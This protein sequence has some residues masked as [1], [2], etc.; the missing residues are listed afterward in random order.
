MKVLFV[1]KGNTCR[2]PMAEA[3]LRML[4]PEW[5]VAS[6]GTK[7]NC[8]G[9]SASSHAQSV[10]ADCGG[11]LADHV[12]REFTSEMA[13]QD[14]IIFVMAESN[15]TEILKIAPDA[16]TKVKLL[17]GKNDI[18]NPFRG[19]LAKYEKVF[20]CIKIAVENFVNESYRAD[21]LIFLTKRG[22][23]TGPTAICRQMR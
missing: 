7:K 22:V 13:A 10:I 12:S 16:E 6:A 21:N 5:T 20:N 15:K 9:K 19:D 17:G 2:S 23:N 3:Y 8:G 11:S 4:K 1:C 18:S 14:D